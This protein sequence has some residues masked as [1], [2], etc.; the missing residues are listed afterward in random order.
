MFA[1]GLKGRDNLADGVSGRRM[2]KTFSKGYD[3]S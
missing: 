3:A 2:L 1:E